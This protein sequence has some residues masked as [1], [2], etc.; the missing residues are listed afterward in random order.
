MW[1]KIVEGWN[2]SSWAAHP[3]E[4]HKPFEINMDIVNRL[5]GKKETEDETKI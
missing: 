4:D 3:E 5:A 2:E 1:R